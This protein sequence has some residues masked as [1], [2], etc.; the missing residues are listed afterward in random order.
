MSVC[1]TLRTR[2]VAFLLSIAA[3]ATPHAAPLYWDTN[4]AAVYSGNAGGTWGTDAFWSTN[5][6]GLAP[7]GAYVTG[8]EAVFAA[9][10]DG[11]G[12]Y[13]VTLGSN[14]SATGL[15]FQE[16]HVTIAPATAP[17]TGDSTGVQV[18]TLTGTTP[19]ILVQNMDA[20]ISTKI[21]SSGMTKTGVGKLTLN[22]GAAN[23]GAFFNFVGGVTTINGGTLELAGT[24]SGADQTSFNNGMVINSGGT[25]LWGGNSNNIQNS[26]VFT[27]NTGG[28]LAF[29][30]GTDFVGN[31]A[32]SG[33]V[34]LQGGSMNLGTS[35]N[36]TFSGLIVGSGNLQASSGN[37]IL[38]LTN[39]NTFGGTL[40]SVNTNTSTGGF[41][42]G[43]N[44]A[45]QNATL[46]LNNFDV[47]K[48]NVSFGNGIGTFV[49]GGLQGIGRLT[50][51]DAGGSAITLQVGN[52][53]GSTTY[54][55]ALGGTG[56]LTK[57]GIG[58]LML[59]GEF[60]TVTNTTTS[61][62]VSAPGTAS[63]TYTGD[64]TI[65]SG[66]HTNAGIS[67]GNNTLSTLKLDFNAA[68]NVSTSVSSVTY[69]TSATAATSNIISSSSRL[70][71]GGGRL[72]VAGNNSGGTASQT[73]NNTLLKASRSYVTVTQGTTHGDTVVNLGNITREPGAVLEFTLPTGTQSTANGI[74]TTTANDVSGILGGWALVGNEWAV[75]TTAGTTLGN[76]V[77][78]GAG[79][80]TTY[81]GAGIVSSATSNLLINDASSTVDTPSGLSE[82]NT[83]MVR[84][85]VA[86]GAAVNRALDIAS[87]ETLRLGVSGSI[88]NQGTGTLAVG[89]ATNVGTITAGGAPD[90]AGEVIIN[91][92]GGGELTLNSSVKDNGTGAVTLIRIG[93]GNQVVFKG[94]NTHTGGT[95]FMQ[96]RNRV[97]SGAALG[98]G[99]VTVTAGGQLWLNT[100]TTYTHNFFLAGSGY[101]EG[102]IPGAIRFSGTNT[103]GNSGSLITLT[104]DTRL[105]SVNG[106]TGILA[107][108]ITGDYALDLS[109]GAGGTNILTLA[110]P[111]NDFTGN[112]SINT[113]LN[114][115]TAFNTAII[116][117]RLDASEVIP[118]GVGK[119]NVILSGGS[120]GT[121]P[122]TLDLNGFSETINGLISYSGH[123]NTFVT[124]GKAGTTSVLTLGDNNSSTLV[125]ASATYTSFFGGVIK[126]NNAGTGI[127]AITKIGEGV[128]TFTG[129]NTYSGVT[130]INKGILQA[131][132]VNTLSANSAVVIANDATA[133]LA[134]TNGIADFS[135]TIKSLSGG[136]TVNLGTIAAADTVANPATRLTTGDSSD[137]TY[138]GTMVGAGGLVKQGSGRFTLTGINTY[139][140]TTQVTAGNLQVG[141]GG[142]GQSGTGAV[143][144]SSGATLSGS[145]AV[146][147]ATTVNGLLSV[148]DNGG[149]GIGR[150]TFTDVSAS[151]LTL[152]GGGSSAAPRAL[153]T[154]AGATGNEANPVDGIQTAGLLNTG[155]GNHDFLQVQGTLNLSAGSTI[156]IELGSGYSPSWGDVFNLIDWG[157]VNGGAGAIVA[158]GFNPSAVG[159][160]LDLPVS[161]AMTANGWFWETN[162]FL[163]DGIVYV[164]PEPGRA[165][166]LM[167]G[168]GFLAGRRRRGR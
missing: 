56:G 139:V 162:Q 3:F 128:Q 95:I 10:I 50:L 18:L 62:V 160:D 7:T 33:L 60:L 79:A 47:S 120:T 142:S 153:F 135:Q 17:V 9:G 154:L 1:R 22:Y 146:Q 75:K 32:G 150:L 155:V 166:L 122:V 163:T 48:I 102:G 35:G 151:S 66:T 92:S 77:A 103:I 124:N 14:Q 101:G 11:T 72:L 54:R 61:T 65:L 99:P 73:F 40:A 37:G 63:N 90:T 59:T 38:T 133:M 141:Q 36:T 119:G 43:H 165:L 6:N 25:F 100:N 112:L 24:A 44:R 87:G 127:V 138:S 121:N 110:N 67:V 41:R 5:A 134:L 123:A 98:T 126:D 30:V 136:G 58:T 145:G 69:V 83:V 106:A 132:A 149:T 34:S 93:A 168:L 2:L 29:R 86:D 85:S 147:G 16:G 71:L 114:G 19:S 140:G 109:G 161:A 76:V 131:G 57:I 157:T 46:S 53:D 105:G 49:V 55:G 117:V 31:L 107:G 70:V 96:G 113:N 84:N 104:G 51:Q 125:A 94:T 167:I 80:Y 8:S 82:L 111:A 4:G 137:T 118:N 39:A 91:N 89:T 28:V 108:K 158:G 156:K 52:N 64:T 78:A 152:A 115:T 68:S 27:V 13:T 42:L 116:T 12:T 21:V 130:T 144:V 159:G 15:T 81:A 23:A 45:A 97:D 88:W 20:V 164:V 148:G 74:T 129:A 143:S 26:T